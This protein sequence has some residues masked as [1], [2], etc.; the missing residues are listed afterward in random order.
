MLLYI[1]GYISR[2][3]P[4]PPKVKVTRDAIIE[5]AVTLTRK[6]GADSINA[7]NIAAA[8]NCST[9][10]IFSNFDTMNAL[11]LSVVI[12][13][14]ELFKQYNI[15]EIELHHSPE[16]K[17]YGMSYI[18]FAKEEPELFK[19]LF[20]R[21]RKDISESPESLFFDQMVSVVQGNTGLGVDAANLFHLEMWAFVHGIATMYATGY[22]DLDWSLVSQ[23]L[24]DAYQGLIKKHT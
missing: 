19:L 22:L 15:Q 9:Q 23:M 2:R 14:T 10:P 13:A 6:Q 20:M 4:I 8:L 3:N 11:R 21:D 5:T 18:R 17:A 12:K 16:Y 24:S 7:R 1:I